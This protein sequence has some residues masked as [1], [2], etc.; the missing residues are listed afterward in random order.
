MQGKYTQHIIISLLGL[1]LFS[2]RLN[3]EGSK[4]LSPTS[5]DLVNTNLG[6]TLG[7]YD[8]TD[9]QRLYI[10]IKN[11]AT[12]QVFLGFSQPRS[13]MAYP[14]TAGNANVY[15][16]IKNAAGAVV[17]PTAGNANGQLITPNITG[18]ATAAAGPSQI[19]G[20]SGYTATVFNPAAFGNGDYYIE[21]SRTQG[22]F[23]A[24]ASA[25]EWWDITVATKTP[26]PVALNGRVF[27]KNWALQTP[28]INCAGGSFTCGVADAFGQFDRPFNH[29]WNTIQLNTYFK[30]YLEFRIL[31]DFALKSYIY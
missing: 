18:W 4:Q 13:S 27:T 9:V 12:E 20:A 3:A 15:Y 14:C 8:G 22:A 10:H 31:V 26:T 5:T 17:F 30:I 19:V 7:R 2:S 16:R 28:A 29:F 11:A 25:I 24:T 23:S 1:L 21:F 6:S